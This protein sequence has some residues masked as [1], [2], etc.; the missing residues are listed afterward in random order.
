MTDM[1]RVQPEPVRYHPRPCCRVAGGPVPLETH[2]ALQHVVNEVACEALAA[3][4]M[5][6]VD[7]VEDVVPVGLLEIA[8]PAS[9]CHGVS[10]YKPEPPPVGVLL[11]TM[12]S[13]DGAA[14]QA[15]AD[16]P[17]LAGLPK[18]VEATRKLAR[19]ETKGVFDAIAA[20]TVAACEGPPPC[21]PS[22]ATCRGG[23]LLNAVRCLRAKGFGG[24]LLLAIAA[25]EWAKLDR[26]A[27]EVAGR[28][29]AETGGNIVVL[30]PC[31]DH[32]AVLVAPGG[33]SVRLV[34]GDNYALKWLATDG[35]H[36]TFALTV[37]Y[38]VI[39]VDRCAVRVV[40]RRSEA[41]EEACS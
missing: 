28:L 24:D 18:L 9:V 36:H 19:A 7:Y 21:E 20:A 27:A 29:R 30:P 34:I 2:T 38:R 15:L 35:V 25:D 39:V 23:R 40:W 4:R 17:H 16:S 14:L 37:G 1:E 13:L 11:L 3:R 8:E 33:E 5:L 41:D 26:E 32:V 12:V 22:E 31:G 10:L 6:D